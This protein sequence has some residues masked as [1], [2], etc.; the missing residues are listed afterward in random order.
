MCGLKPAPL[1]GSLLKSRLVDELILYIAPKIMGSDGQGL[2]GH[3]GF[4]RMEDIL[5]LDI[6]AVS[7]V[8]PDIRVTAVPKY[9]G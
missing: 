9:K 1:A 3:M 7:V 6:K 8:G 4:E 2:F 5:E